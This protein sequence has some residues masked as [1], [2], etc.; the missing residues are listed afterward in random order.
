MAAKQKLGAHMSIAGG[1]YHAFTHGKG[2]GCDTMQIFTKSSNQWRAKSLGKEEIEEYLRLQEETG[3]EPVV[4]HTSYLINIASSDKALN[5][6]SREALAI[7]VERCEALQIPFLVLH[8]GSHLGAGEEIGIKNIAGALDWVHVQT[9]RAKAKIALETTAG[10]GAHLGF[11]FEQ[12][13]DMIDLTKEK[14]RLAVCLD[15]CHVFAAGY[16]IRTEKGYEQTIADFDRTVGLDR[17]GAIHFND[18]KKGLGSRV[19][20]HEHIGKGF[21]GKEAFGFFLNDKR[22]AHIPK[23]LETPKGPDY[24]EDKINL[25]VL[26]KLIK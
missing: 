3:I 25:A 16:D 19:D 1:V 20:R 26:R 24:K 23:I 21:L 9:P 2:A 4:A 17:L 10:Q 5:Q 18:S 11:K 22:L 13:R 8:P 6:K 15:T 12:L 14:E 7:E